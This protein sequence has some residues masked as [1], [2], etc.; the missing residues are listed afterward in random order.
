MLEEYKTA[1]AKPKA[2]LLTRKTILL[3]PNG[4]QVLDDE[5]KI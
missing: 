3:T 4:R 1:L 2:E 5:A